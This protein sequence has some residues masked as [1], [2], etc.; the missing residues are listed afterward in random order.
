MFRWF[1]FCSCW[2]LLHI[3]PEAA[4]LPTGLPEFGFSGWTWVASSR[5]PGCWACLCPGPSP[6]LS[7]CHHSTTLPP[8][9]SLFLRTLFLYYSH[10]LQCLLTSSPISIAAVTLSP[11]CAHTCTYSPGRMH[12]TVCLSSLIT[13]ALFS[14]RFYPSL[15]TETFILKCCSLSGFL[16]QWGTFRHC[17]FLS[18]CDFWHWQPC[19]PSSSQSWFCCHSSGWSPLFRGSLLSCLLLKGSVC[20]SCSL[21]HLLWFQ[22]LCLCLWP[23]IL[24]VACVSSDTNPFTHFLWPI[25]VLLSR[26]PLSLRIPPTSL[27]PGPTPALSILYPI[28]VTRPLATHLLQ[29]ETYTS[30][31]FSSH[32]WLVTCLVSK[33]CFATPGT[34]ALQASLSMG[35]SRQEYWSG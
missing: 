8:I 14:P 33:L 18:L 25:S 35:F 23:R 27:S 17:L 19:L 7:V 10:V 21:S 30:L 20:P 4:S 26:G 1:Y 28:F 2:G 12:H 22:L 34:V 29:L 5:P 11:M 13:H 32:V 3:L 6:G 15:P 9:F 24:S 16:L 31:P